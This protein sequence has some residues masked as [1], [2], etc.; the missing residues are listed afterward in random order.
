MLEVIVFDD[1]SMIFVF[2]VCVVV[3]VLMMSGICYDDFLLIDDEF[4]FMMMWDV[5]VRLV[6]V[7]VVICCFCGRWLD[8]VF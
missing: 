3:S 2:W 5:V 7:C 6:W 4:I 1:M 8:V